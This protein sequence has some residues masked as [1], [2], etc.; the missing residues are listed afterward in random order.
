MA[1]YGARTL[2]QLQW[3]KVT[4]ESL[5]KQID[6]HMRGERF[7]KARGGLRYKQWKAQC[8]AYAR[9]KALLQLYGTQGHPP[10]GEQHD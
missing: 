1:I 3:G 2:E 10:R 8:A 7:A 5:Q 6:Q 4:L 9:E